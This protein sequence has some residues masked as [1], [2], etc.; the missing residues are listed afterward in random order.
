MAPTQFWSGPGIFGANNTP[1][2]T[3]T[4]GGIYSVSVS[5]TLNACAG[6]AT[7]NVLGTTLLNLDISAS[8]TLLCQPAPAATLQVNG[9][10]DSYSWAPFISTNTAIAVTPS[11][12]TTYTVYGF[13]S[14]CSGSA[15]ITVSANVTPVLVSA[16]NATTCLG[17]VAGLSMGGAATYT[18]QPGNLSGPTVTVSPVA[19]ALYTITGM[20]GHCS[21]TG[22]AAVLVSPVP[23][24]ILSSLPGTICSGST[25]SLSVLG[26]NAYTWQPG[27][28][29][30][31]SQ[32]VSPPASMAYTVMGVYLSTGCASTATVQVIVTP[33]P[34]L[35]L[36]PFSLTVCAGDAAALSAFGASGY[37]WSPGGATVATPTVFPAASSVYTV[38]GANSGCTSTATLAISVNPKPIITVSTNVTNLCSGQ[39]ATLSASGALNY[40]WNPAA[41]SGNSLIITPLASGA[42]TFLVTGSN[43]FGCSTSTIF[44]QGVGTTPT[45]IAVASPTGVC[46][47]GSVAL[48]G[49]G[50]NTF[51]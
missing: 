18:W 7:V 30:G 21:A 15:V 14:A 24:L 37:I 10:A 41:S 8:G 47:G 1:T 16:G 42:S 4:N 11:V 23:S 36:S 38:Q 50:A 25:N 29:T 39:S 20:S 48:N 5:N 3:V 34:T 26:A 9:A 27:N 19:S 32:Q 28:L 35:V 31:A 17:S 45:L 12:T 33:T 22:T 2:I 44:T 6:T 51:F 13:T 49:G 43:A 40:T 46:Q